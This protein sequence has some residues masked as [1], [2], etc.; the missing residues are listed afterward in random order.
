[1]GK[2]TLTFAAVVV[3]SLLLATNP[4]DGGK[5]KGVQRMFIPRQTIKISGKAGVLTARCLEVQ[6]ETPKSQYGTSMQVM[7]GTIVVTREDAK[8]VW[9][10]V[11]L[12][13]AIQR[14]WLSMHGSGYTK[15][16]RFP[17]HDLKLETNGELGVTYQV[18]VKEPGLA[19]HLPGT[20]HE[21]EVDERDL[22]MVLSGYQARQEGLDKLHGRLAK[23]VA[24]L[25]P[26][27]FVRE[28]AQLEL[29]RL[30]AEKPEI[31]KKFEGMKA[32]EQQ[33][34]RT[35][36]IK[37]IEAKLLELGPKAR[38]ILRWDDADIEDWVYWNALHLDADALD[39]V[40]AEYLAKPGVLAKLKYNLDA[41]LHPEIYP[42]LKAKSSAAGMRGADGKQYHLAGMDRDQAAA[43]QAALPPAG[44][45]VIF[46]VPGEGPATPVRV[47]G[48]ALLVPERCSSAQRDQVRLILE[49]LDRCSPAVRADVLSV[50]ARWREVTSLRVNHAITIF[51]APHLE[52]RLQNGSYFLH[53]GDS[54]GKPPPPLNLT[55][56]LGGNDPLPP[57]WQRLVA[58]GAWLFATPSL[59]PVE[60]REAS[61]LC[62]RFAAR[63][64]IRLQRI[65]D[66]GRSVARLASLPEAGQERWVVDDSIGEVDPALPGILRNL[67]AR[68]D[69][70]NAG[71]IS[72]LAGHATPAAL[73]EWIRRAES[74]QFAGND[75][76]VL[77]CNVHADMEQ[78]TQAALRHGAGSVVL[79]CDRIDALSAALVVDTYT[80]MAQV[81][82]FDGPERLVAA[83]YGLTLD[84]LATCMN[85]PTEA[86]R[87]EALRE[88][89]GSDLAS[90]FIESR[91]TGV[92]VNEERLQSVRA[93]L[94]RDQE[95][96][97]RTA[98]TRPVRVPRYSPGV[99]AAHAA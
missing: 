63:V 89:F 40:D 30:F 13:T 5:A 46:I 66:G 57:E 54:S 48:N 43:L 23:A 85:H 81:R 16:G 35:Q 36:L 77:A 60:I 62:R 21:R 78:F 29:Y 39:K 88:S 74:G 64:D 52:V 73:R 92:K 72:V 90:F 80:R 12:Q 38:K 69:R 71:N 67:I 84:R 22:P 93:A 1:M 17:W 42:K 95:L 10:P 56:F 14:G 25:S 47:I 8:S 75:V 41:I 15:D 49:A 45:S 83:V 2:L 58:R 79:P 94:R 4:A 61:R 7:S 59:Q 65:T 9:A 33:V 99:L 11:S 19:T 26:S 27:V 32:E 28:M 18:E 96:F 31:Q 44:D 20:L 55:T 87:I 24:G 68:A 34:I 86:A 76:V 70:P 3:T 37:G 51:S 98:D 91:L 6:R 50:A 82:E 97:E 53:S